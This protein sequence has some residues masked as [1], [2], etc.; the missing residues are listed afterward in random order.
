MPSE[1]YLWFHN[2][3]LTMLAADAKREIQAIP[4]DDPE[5]ANKRREILRMLTFNVERLK[6][7]YFKKQ[8]M[9]CVECPYLDE[10]DRRVIAGEVEPPCLTR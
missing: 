5:K 8:E 6:E 7:H 9:K 2:K 4:D 10:H 3:L 1:D